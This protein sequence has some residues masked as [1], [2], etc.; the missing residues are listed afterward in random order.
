MKGVVPEDLRRDTLFP[1]KDWEWIR[2]GSNDL[3]AGCFVLRKK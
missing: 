3:Q 2:D 1:E